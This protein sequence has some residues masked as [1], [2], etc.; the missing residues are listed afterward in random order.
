MLDGL[1]S[2]AVEIADS[3]GVRM[4]FEVFERIAPVDP[5][6]PGA[7]LAGFLVRAADR[8]GWRL[9]LEHDRGGVSF[10]NFL[11]DPTAAPVLDG[12]GPVGGGMH[13]R[14][15]WVDLRS[16]GRRIDLLAALLE[17]LRES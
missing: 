13:T 10:P 3:T 12:L 14:E 5:S 9:E 2:M 15:E 17:H 1:Q 8:A 4:D 11:E 16:L 7:E 6:G